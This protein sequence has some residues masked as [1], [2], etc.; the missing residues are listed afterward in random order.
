[1]AYGQIYS[2]LVKPLDPI[3][4]GSVIIS[5]H[6]RDYTGA[7]T[8]LSI[9]E[10]QLSIR[11]NFEDWNSSHL[12]GMTVVV[13]IQ[14]TGANYF[15]LIGLMRAKE[16]EYKVIIEHG[17]QSVFTRL[18]EGFI[19][20]ELTT[21][22][23][24]KYQQI[25]IVASSYIKKLEN[26]KP[27]SIETLQNKTF[28]D[29]I[30][31]CLS[32]TGSTSNIRVNT[33]Y[34]PEEDVLTIT[35]SQTFLNITGI[36]TE[37]FWK[38]N[39]D[40][41]SSFAILEE[42]CK[43]FSLYIYWWNNRWYIEQ[44]SDLWKETKNYVEYTYGVSYS[45]ADS[46][47]VV[48]EINPIRNVSEL[49]F[50]EMSQTLSCIPGVRKNS[51]RFEFQEFLNF[52][53]RD[54]TGIVAIPNDY[55]EFLPI[56]QWYKYQPM[57]SIVTWSA[58][59]EPYKTMINS[60]KRTIPDDGNNGKTIYDNYYNQ[61]PY[62]FSVGLYTAFLAT[63]SANVS[64]EMSFKYSVVISYDLAAL[65]FDFPWW[66]AV[67]KLVNG[68]YSYHGMIA[69]NEVDSKWERYYDITEYSPRHHVNHVVIKGSD[70]N[71]D[72]KDTTVNFSVSEI[73]F[74][75]DGDYAFKLCIG[76]EKAAGFFS[77]VPL[78][79]YIG[80]INVQVSGMDVE[81]NLIEG[82]VDEDYLIEEEETLMI[83]DISK[84]AN[85]RNAILRGLNLESRTTKWFASDSPPTRPV[86]DWHLIYKS[87][88]NH[89]TRQRLTGNIIYKNYGKLINTGE[90]LVLFQE[91]VLRPFSLFIEDKQS[92][93]KYVLT[94]ISDHNPKH[95][96]YEIQLDEYDNE[97]DLTII[98]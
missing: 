82:E 72:T 80:D 45:P 3:S 53:I 19:N 42:I 84:S 54:L 91:K 13:S 16:K 49:L 65:A 90:G 25:N 78:T 76:I 85:F 48:E 24:L 40:R 87:K 10:D 95:Q 94:G 79:A 5:F 71:K 39:I 50:A 7:E 51:V 28:I 58:Q 86:M 43:T 18:F 96:R 89:T 77:Y 34:V 14:N 67:Y 23:Y 47:I 17:Y 27:A 26:A 74:L 62:L 69:Y 66:L 21:Q 81:P 20:V 88:L 9:N 56:R 97:T 61:P 57:G 37:I 55:K 2:I 64:I 1:M 63:Y 12:I 4:H 32:A 98:V 46:G 6:K 70:F 31:E 15:D 38:N 36:Y 59:G 68:V 35:S 93:L 30:S 73:N 8:F 44:Y 33:S 22:K 41:E 29:L 52:V 75:D 11:R 83:A 92:N 60:I